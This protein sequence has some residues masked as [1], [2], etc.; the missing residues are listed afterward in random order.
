[1]TALSTSPLLRLP[2]ELRLPIYHFALDQTGEY[3]PS[4]KSLSLL[5]TCRQIYIEARLIPYSYI[6]VSIK[7]FDEYN[8]DKRDEM[9]AP[10][11]IRLLRRL[12]PWQRRAVSL[13]VLLILPSFTTDFETNWS[14]FRNLCNEAGLRL[15]VLSVTACEGDSWDGAALEKFPFTKF[16][17]LLLHPKLRVTYRCTKSARPLPDAY[18]EMLE[19]NKE[20]PRADAGRDNSGNVSL[21]MFV[22][23]GHLTEER[24][25]QFLQARGVPVEDPA[26]RSTYVQLV[27][28]FK[29]LQTDW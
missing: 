17:E 13:E 21:K 10:S 27:P 23:V 16:S 4:R 24:P 3:L 2:L 8:Y 18:V 5:Q 25:C 12:L 20:L 6:T 15:K 26:C 1:M 14:T 9:N 29:V 7:H 11:G 22:G 19:G 28:E